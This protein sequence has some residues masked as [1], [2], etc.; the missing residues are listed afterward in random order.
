MGSKTI[1]IEVRR[2]QFLLG[3]EKLTRETGLAIGGCGCCNSP[4]LGE[5]EHTPIPDEAGYA[6]LASDSNGWEDIKWIEPADSY[7][8]E[9]HADKIVKAD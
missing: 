3:L 2:K 9:N 7:D 4:W 8:W 6:D 5:V 1:P